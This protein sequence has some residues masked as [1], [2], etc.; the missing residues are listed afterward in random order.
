MYAAR[1]GADG[2]GRH[3]RS[4]AGGRRHRPPRTTSQ[5]RPRACRSRRRKAG[6]RSRPKDGADSKEPP[7][8]AGPGRPPRRATGAA[9]ERGRRRR[10]L[11]HAGRGSRGRARAGT[12]LVLDRASAS[13][14]PAWLLIYWLMS[15]QR[16]E[17]F[18]MLLASF[19][20]LA[21]M[22]IA[23][24]GSIVFGLATPTEAAAVGAFGGL[25]LA[26]AYRYVAARQ[27]K[28]GNAVIEDDLGPRR[29]HQGV[30]VPDR[31]D[32]RDGVLAVRRL[33]DL[34]GGVR[35]ARRPGDHRALGAVA[36]PDHA[37]V[38]AAQPV[39]HLH[40]GL[41]AGVDRD[42]RHLHADLHSAAAPSSAST[43]CSS[44]CW[45]R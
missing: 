41:A 40:P 44:A 31:Q 5:R 13:A 39:H 25:L 8:D 17:I 42:H 38:H 2:R 22:I 16:L 20:P 7:A 37:A 10:R 18:K 45:W 33:V 34:L 32:Q 29:H 19:F 43:R 4:G 23:V 30:V 1:D 21:V 27:A 9:A 36:R 35:A 15:W 3:D 11:R 12:H 26:G 28:G 24:L 6:C 14:W